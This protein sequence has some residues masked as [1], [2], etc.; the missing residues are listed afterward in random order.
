MTRALPLLVALALPAAAPA[1]EVE[2]GYGHEVLTRGPDWQEVSLE[3]AWRPAE[4]TG[5]AIGA[6]G[7]ERF[8]LRDLDLRVAAS[9][10]LGAPWTVAAE[11]AASPEHHV[12]PAF[13]GGASLQRVLG[14]GFVGSG[15]LRWSRW[16]TEA[17]RTDAALGSLGIERYWSAFRLGWTG[18]L[19]RVA[20][21]WAPSNAVAWDVYFGDRDRV[22]VILA[23]GREVDST[24]G[25]APVVS[26]VL[27]AAVRGRQGLGAAWALVYEVDVQRQGDFYTRGG[28]RVGL[29]RSF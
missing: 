7:L 18:T 9:A 25:P 1:A 13:G 23:A 11:A 14:G 24:G 29:R 8:G 6:R 12:V 26:T 21:Q 16:E 2:A 20:S 22:G 15:G 10:P 3:T 19:A 5:V 27:A 17:G 4:R 28:A